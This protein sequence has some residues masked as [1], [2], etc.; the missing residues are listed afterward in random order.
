MSNHSHVNI[1]PLSVLWRRID[2]KKVRRLKVT[3]QALTPQ[4][5]QVSKRT[6]TLLKAKLFKIYQD[7]VKLQ[8]K[9]KVAI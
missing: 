1:P 2:V 3:V 6:I 8:H 9:N 5:E 7:L 4:Y